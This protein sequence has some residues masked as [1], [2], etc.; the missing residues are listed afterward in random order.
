MKAQEEPAPLLDPSPDPASAAADD[1]RNDADA[2]ADLTAA[3]LYAESI[4]ETIHEPLLVLLPDLRVKSANP[5]FFRHFR[6][7]PAETLGRRIYELGNGQWNIPALR[8]LL[9]DVLPANHVFNDFEVEHEFDELGRRVMLLNA[10]RLDHVQLILLGIQDVTERQRAEEAVRQAAER[11]AFRIGLADALRPLAGPRD[12]QDAAARLLGV[13]LGASRVHY[14]EVS[15]DG[16]YGLVLA[17]YCDGVPS[18]V[19]RYRFDDYGPAVMAEFRAGRTLV[20]ADVAADPRLSPAEREATARFSVGA[21]VLVPLV[22]DGRPTAVLVVHQDRPRAWRGDEVALVEEVAERTWEAVERS[23]A[24]SALRRSERHYRQLFESIDEA[25]CVMQV[26]LDASGR[27]VDVIVLEA[28][29][30]F[31]R[32]AG[33]EGAVGRRIRDLVPQMESTWAERYGRIVA[34]GRGERFTDYSPSLGRWFEVDAFPFGDAQERRVAALFRDV[35]ARVRSEAELIESERRFRIMADTAPA[36]LWMSNRQHQTTL[37]SR[38]WSDFTGQPEKEGL[39]MGWTDAVHP[40]DRENAAQAF[41]AAAREREPFTIEYRLRRADGAWRWAV[42]AGRPRYEPNGDFAGYVGGVIDIDDRRRAEEDLRTATARLHAVFDALAEGVAFFD[43]HGRVVQTNRALERAFAPTLRAL[44]NPGAT[45][46]PFVHPDGTPLPREDHPALAVLRNGSPR[47]DVEVGVRRDGGDICWRLV[48]AQPVRDEGGRMLGAVASFVDITQRKRAEEALRKADRL[49]DEFLATLSHELRNPLTPLVAGV[50]TMQ[51]SA[52]P[53]V[54]QR[55]LEMMERQLRQ[56]VRLTDDLLE[57]SR[58]TRGKVTLRP[59][60]MDLAAAVRS[61]V[62]ATGDGLQA[63]RVA[64]ELPEAPVWIRGDPERITQ[65]IGNLLSNAIKFTAAHG[66]IRVRV[67]ATA[68]EAVIRVEDDGVG[69]APGDLERVFEIFT[70]VADDDGPP[71]AGLGIGLALVHQLVALHGGT[72]R[73]CSEGRNRGAEFV[74]TLPLPAEPPADNVLA[75]ELHEFPRRRV[76]VVDDN[77]DVADSLR[78]L[79]EVAGQDV[80]V[81]HS[82]REALAKAPAFR[83]DLVLLDI[84]MPELDGHATCRA[85]RREPWSGQATIVALTGWGQEEDRRKSTEAGFDQHLVKPVNYAR[86]ARLL[87]GSVG[88]QHV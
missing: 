41:L 39:G 75:P 84:G 62:E 68:H 18:V 59:A 70:Q 82:G 72:V 15:E 86:L 19:G 21:Y 69:I 3:K 28:N 51:A 47:R 80:E 66:V 67:E 7:E 56:L 42:D 83:P 79:L 17:D 57:V 71:R 27:G 63:R 25:F 53:R 12:I 78:L 11:D 5:A 76:L 88:A 45:R 29:P 44:S 34:T 60:R 35:T 30:A 46:S 52:D 23:R 64:L 49:K 74:V 48:N 37:L 24:E 31:E 40:D 33:I 43:P 61:A 22:K 1:S 54:R 14:G 2:F 20:V 26:L 81:A 16:E 32:H 85:M 38:A 6:V 4:V 8:R 77:P 58:I 73:A 50:R 10:R 87:G 9:E 13:H 36:M 55:S 65:V